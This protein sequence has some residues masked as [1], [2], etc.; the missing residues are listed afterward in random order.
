[1]HAFTAAHNRFAFYFWKWELAKDEILLTWDGKEEISNR[2]L[3]RKN[4][5]I[6]HNMKTPEPSP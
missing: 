1:M 2:Q 6:I 3:L 4:L 5:G